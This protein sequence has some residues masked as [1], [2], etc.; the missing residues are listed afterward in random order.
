LGLIL[1]CLWLIVMYVLLAVLGFAK[2]SDSDYGDFTEHQWKDLRR[3][4]LRRCIA[5]DAL[6]KAEAL[7]WVEN[8]TRPLKSALEQY[9]AIAA[10][11]RALA[12]EVRS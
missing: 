2:R 10:D 11:R 6:R 12:R 1:A 4:E 9:D 8:L 7:R 3:D 5:K